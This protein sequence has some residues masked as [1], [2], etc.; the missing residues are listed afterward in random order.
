MF[1]DT[2]AMRKE[3]AK[4]T[5]ISASLIEHARDSGKKRG[6]KKKKVLDAL[7]GGRRDD[8]QRRPVHPLSGRVFVAVCVG[9]RLEAKRRGQGFV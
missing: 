6:E 8:A 3:R 2:L 5:T 4:N 9:R 7:F 1:I